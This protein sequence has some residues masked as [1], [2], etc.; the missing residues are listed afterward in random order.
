MMHMIRLAF[1]ILATFL[2]VYPAAHASEEGAGRAL[3]MVSTRNMDPAQEAQFNHWYNEIDLP[4]VFTVPGYLRARRGVQ[5]AVPGYPQTALKEGLGRY[6]AFYDIES[7]N[8]DWTI[9]DMLLLAKKMGNTGRDTPLLDVTERV[10]FHQQGAPLAHAAP[11]QGT[12][13]LFAVRSDEPAEASPERQAAFESWYHAV[14]LPA[15]LE[16]G[17]FYRATRYRLHR[18]V[19]V[20]PVDMPGYLTL[21]EGR[22]GSGKDL[23]DAYAQAMQALEISGQMDPDYQALDMRLYARLVDAYRPE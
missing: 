11:E 19:M 9:T 22:A 16:Q 8:L 1:G 23:L 10:Y 21:F 14:F 7:V 12:E 13:Y 18:V 3:M 6:V 17:G 2:F 4:D 15:V 20:L 5:Q